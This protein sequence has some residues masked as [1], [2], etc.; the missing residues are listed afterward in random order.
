MEKRVREGRGT[1]RGRRRRGEEE[2]EREVLETHEKRETEES[3]SEGK[4]ELVKSLLW[5]PDLDAS[6]CSLMVPWPRTLPGR[7][8]TSCFFLPVERVAG[9]GS[10]DTQRRRLERRTSVTEMRFLKKKRWLEG[11]FDKCFILLM[12]LGDYFRVVSS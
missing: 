8:I 9:R 1:G 2:G 4:S 5:Q 10:G 6:N 7:E 3:N 12:I 11:V